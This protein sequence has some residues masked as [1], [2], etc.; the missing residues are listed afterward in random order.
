MVVAVAAVEELDACGSGSAAAV[1]LIARG[2]TD[3]AIRDGGGVK[4][5]EDA[6]TAVAATGAACS[7]ESNVDAGACF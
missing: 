1:T 7:C 3:A 6:S 5:V 4:A 2:P